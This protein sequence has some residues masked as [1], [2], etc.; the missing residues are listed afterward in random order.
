[1]AAGPLIKT[2]IEIMCDIRGYLILIGILLTGFS[3]SFAVSMPDNEAFEN[4]VSGPLVGLLTTF[5]AVVGSFHMSDYQTTLSTASFLFFLFLNVI[6]MLNLLIAIMSD[7]Y[8]KVKD[9]EVVE[10]LK[11][12]AETIIAEEA[13]MSEADWRNASYFPA[14]LEVLQAKEKPDI[15]WSGVSGQISKLDKKVTEKVGEAEQAVKA[16][17]KKVDK[18]EDKVDEMS[19]KVEALQKDMDAKLERILRALTEADGALKLGP[20]PEPEPEP[21]AEPEPEPKTATTTTE[22]QPEPEPEPEPEPAP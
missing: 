20:E 14:Y 15:V 8:E 21:E 5:K 12:R 11:L 1:M 17:S 2:V 19:S 3:V 6:V 16:V 22:L 7:S 13:M 18:V 10:A 4:G 9:G